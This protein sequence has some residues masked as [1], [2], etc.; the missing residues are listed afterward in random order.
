VWECA[1][2]AID[3]LSKILDQK[4][5]VDLAQAAAK[6]GSALY[7]LGAKSEA[8]KAFELGRR[9]SPRLFAEKKF[10]YRI[11]AQSLGPAVAEEVSAF[12]RRWLPREIRRI[13]TF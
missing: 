8:K 3:A 4:Y 1:A 10:S 9:L 7:Y 12:C 5:R 11:L 13:L 6:A 2:Q